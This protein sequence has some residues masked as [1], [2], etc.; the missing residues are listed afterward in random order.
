MKRDCR[1]HSD[2]AAAAHHM[3]ESKDRTMLLP[4]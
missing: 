2:I 4:L 3:A 1:D